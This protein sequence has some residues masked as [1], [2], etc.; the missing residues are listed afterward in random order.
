MTKIENK[1]WLLGSMIYGIPII[2][3]LQELL[4]RIDEWMNVVTDFIKKRL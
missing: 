1:F 2:Y 3:D 4:I